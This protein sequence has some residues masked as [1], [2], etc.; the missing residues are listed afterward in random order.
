M[1]WPLL[2]LI[3]ALAMI[4]IA[5]VVVFIMRDQPSTRRSGTLT[6][7]GV[8]A[9]PTAIVLHNAMSALMGVEEGVSF[10]VALVVAPAAVLVGTAGVARRIWPLPSTR[11]ISWGLAAAVAGL[12][13]FALYMLFAVVVTTATGG[14]PPYQGVVEAF[15]VPV[16]TLAVAGGAAL[17]AVSL[18]F[19][20][21]WGA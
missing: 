4:L 16:S 20:K 8:L 11:R 14:N 1:P 19:E 15:V 17:A 6:L 10:L 9:F 2:M 12:A 18:V 7:I 3:L 13:A 5:V 21:R